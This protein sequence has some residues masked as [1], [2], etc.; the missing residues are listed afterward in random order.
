MVICQDHH[1]DVDTPGQSLDISYPVEK[2]NARRGFYG[3]IWHGILDASK[4]LNTPT[5]A[6]K[7]VPRPL[8]PL[9]SGDGY[10]VVD[11]DEPRTGTTTAQPRILGHPTE[12]RSSTLVDYET[13]D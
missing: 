11:L 7:Q 3:Q 12:T 9:A 2:G 4:T 13:H 8:T 10:G 6:P 1:I 5:V